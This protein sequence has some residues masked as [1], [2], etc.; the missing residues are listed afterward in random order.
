MC[1][2]GGYTRLGTGT[3]GTH[4]GTHTDQTTSSTR[5]GGLCPPGL[6]V[7][8]QDSIGHCHWVSGTVSLLSS[9]IGDTDLSW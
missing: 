4:A 2:D 1:T 5:I 7:P 8:R 6:G 9:R 3:R